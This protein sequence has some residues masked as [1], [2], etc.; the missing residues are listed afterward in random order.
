MFISRT[1]FFLFFFPRRGLTPPH[2][3][4]SISM[5]TFTPEEIEFLKSHG[6]E[7]CAKTWLGLWDPKRNVHQ[8]Q[9]ELIIDKYERKRYYLEPGSPLKSITNL[10]SSN[11]KTNSNTN[12]SNSNSSYNHLS[13]GLKSITLTPPSSRGSHSSLNGSLNGSTGGGSTKQTDV[14]NGFNNFLNRKTSNSSVD[15]GSS[16][17]GNCNGSSGFSSDSDFAD[18]GSANIFDATSTNNTIN[19]SVSSNNSSFNSSFKQ[20]NGSILDLHNGRSSAPAVNNENFA[21]FDH[22]PIYNAAG[23]F[24]ILIFFSFQIF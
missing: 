23:E 9:R 15:C 1:F 3:V 17:N 24:V 19:N 10:S 8:D 11:N 18:F 5:A 14:V 16:I 6:N 4:K 12:N 20:Q 7:E 13:N 2:R 22:A 21:D